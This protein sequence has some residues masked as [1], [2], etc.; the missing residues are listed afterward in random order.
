MISE[1]LILLFDPRK[2]DVV[3]K[4]IFA[5]E[6]TRTLW[7]GIK[8][9]RSVRKDFDQVIFSHAK[10]IRAMIKSG[11]L[12]ENVLHDILSG[13]HESSPRGV[14]AKGEINIVKELLPFINGEK[15]ITFEI[16]S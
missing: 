11:P 3:L 6:L 12:D 4:E 1:S 16:G 15:R 14:I 8:P 2:S 9:G 7:L 13:C 5:D 10:I